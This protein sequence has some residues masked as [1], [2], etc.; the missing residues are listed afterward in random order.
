MLDSPVAPPTRAS[1]AEPPSTVEEGRLSE[2]S[3]EFCRVTLW[4]GYRKSRFYAVLDDERDELAVAESELFRFRGNGALE[5]T[6]AIEA[7][8][9]TLIERLLSERWELDGEAVPWYAIRLR[10]R[11]SGEAAAEAPSR[12]G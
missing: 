5:R 1:A 2:P 3:F 6:E 8:H 11:V 4:R 7:V 12:S 10:R 9:R